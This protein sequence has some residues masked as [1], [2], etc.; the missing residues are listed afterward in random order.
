MNVPAR[1]RTVRP[2]FFLGLGLILTLLAATAAGAAPKT[3]KS[4]WRDREVTIDG[5]ADEWEGARTY[6]KKQ[7]IDVGVLNDEEFLY[8]SFVTEDEGVRRQILMQGFKVWV[9]PE[10]VPSFGVQYPLGLRNSGLMPDRG[11]PGGGGP[12]GGSGGFGGG[13]GSGG[14]GGGFGGS[15]GS[16]GFGGGRRASMDPA[17]MGEL[18]DV[19]LEELEILGPGTGE[20]VRLAV[21]ETAGIETAFEILGDRVVYELKIPL[22]QTVEHPHAVGLTGDSGAKPK[23]SVGLVS[24]EMEQGEGRRGGFSFGPGGGG[25]GGGMGGGKGGGSMGGGMGGGGRGGGFGGPGGGRGRSE[26]PELKPFEVWTELQLATP[27]TS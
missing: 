8:L 19:M 2:H 23:L 7:K 27:G 26:R 3:L 5:V 18:V 21:D 12:G 22:V 20:P 1:K 6:L 4:Q 25:R 11:G 9:S 15:G 10:D 24:P 13:S 14:S 17:Q 16:G